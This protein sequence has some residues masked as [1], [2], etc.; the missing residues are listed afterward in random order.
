MFSWNH[1]DMRAWAACFTEDADY[2]NVLGTHWQGRQEIQARHQELHA[3]ALRDSAMRIS[4]WSIRFM[5]AESCLVHM[6]WEMKGGSPRKR[7][8]LLTL[9]LV[10]DQD[11]WRVTA[12]HNSDS[13]PLF[14]Q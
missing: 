3:T 13:L 14:T 11:R 4:E 12:A 1:H 9:V 8:G 7:R 2:I 6:N 10:P 5:S